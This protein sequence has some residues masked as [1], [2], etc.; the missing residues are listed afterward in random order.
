MS[1]AQFIGQEPGIRSAGESGQNPGSDCRAIVSA[2]SLLPVSS[3]TLEFE[4]AFDLPAS[5]VWDA[6]IDP[7][8]LEGWLADATVDPRVGGEY[9]LAWIAPTHLDGP[10]LDAPK[11][12]EGNAA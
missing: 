7:V 6:L 12:D 8:L 4:R 2:R 9:R 3:I 1:C 10:D 11:R 5:I